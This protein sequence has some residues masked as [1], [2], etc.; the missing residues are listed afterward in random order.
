MINPDASR[1]RERSR[2]II[3]LTL[4]N[5]ATLSLPSYQDVAATRIALLAAALAGS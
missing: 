3:S 2:V 1:Y 5:Q 4:F